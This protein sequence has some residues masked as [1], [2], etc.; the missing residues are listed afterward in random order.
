MLAGRPA[1]KRSGKL[2]KCPHRGSHEV[3]AP[4]RPANRSQH[5]SRHFAPPEFFRDIGFPVRTAL[6]SRWDSVE[7]CM[8]HSRSSAN[9]STSM[10]LVLVH[11]LVISSL[12]MIPLAEC[13]ALRHLVYAVDL[14]GFGRSKGPSEILPIPKL[15]SAL[16]CWMT[17][18]GIERC[19]LVAN[20]LG[21]EIAAH[22]AVRTPER[23]ASLV[24]I[25]PTLD[26]R[27]F[28]IPTQTLRLLQDAVREPFR[29]W[30]NWIFDFFRA[31]VRRAVGTTR[32]M[33]KDHIEHQLPLVHARTLLVRGGDDPTVPQR[34]AEEMTDLL[35]QGELMVLPGEPHCVHFTAP[36]AICEA[37][38]R[39]ISVERFDTASPK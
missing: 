21:C 18:V 1:G 6:K 13:L 3:D 19:H 24:L 27:A 36:E 12:Y 31:G 10:P 17:K 14:P 33:F 15:A 35:P 26:P 39:H 8:I 22:V 7:G 30:M 16:S 20:S 29:L 32:E 38:E 5:I 34:A 4:N 9:E 25:G 23:V 37:I 11:G 28:A 2:R